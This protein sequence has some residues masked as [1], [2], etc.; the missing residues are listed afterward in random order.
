MDPQLCEGKGRRERKE[1]IEKTLLP[2]NKV[3][4]SKRLNPIIVL[5]PGLCSL[6]SSSKPSLPCALSAMMISSVLQVLQ[7]GDVVWLTR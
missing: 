3:K 4:K 6:N 2:K 7:L 5:S 1:M